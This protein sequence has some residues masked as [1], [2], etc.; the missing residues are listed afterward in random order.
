MTTLKVLNADSTPLRKLKCIKSNLRIDG[1]AD[2][3]KETL[4]FYRFEKNF[5]KERWQGERRNDTRTTIFGR[6]HHRTIINGENYRSVRDFDFPN[7]VEEAKKR[8]NEFYGFVTLDGL[9]TTKET[10]QNFLDSL[11]WNISMDD[12]LKLNSK[13][14]LVKWLESEGA[15]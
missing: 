2:D 8:H 10:I 3:F 12:F 5:I 6:Y 9:E 15:E 7:S 13:D 14:G 4:S 1:S 11:N